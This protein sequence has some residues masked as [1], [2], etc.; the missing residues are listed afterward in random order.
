MELHRHGGV[1][2]AVLGRVLDRFQAAQVHRPLDVRFAQSDVAGHDRYVD[3]TCRAS[4]LS[5]AALRGVASIGGERPARDAAQVVADGPGLVDQL[6][7]RLG[8][9]RCRIFGLFLCQAQLDPQREDPALRAVVQFALQPA[10]L[11]LASDR[12]P[13]AGLDSSGDA[14]ALADDR[15]EGQRERRE[16]DVELKVERA[17]AGRLLD[18]RSERAGT[19]PGPPLRRPPPRRAS[20]PAGRSAARPRP[21]KGTRGR[22]AG[23]SA[24]SAI[25]LRP[26]T[27]AIISAPSKSLRPR[28]LWG[29]R[30]RPR[31]R[32][33]D[34]DQPARDAS[35][36]PAPPEHGH[37]RSVDDLAGPQGDH[38]DRRADRFAETRRP[39]ERRRRGRASCPSWRAAR[40]AAGG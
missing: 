29:R 18:E 6:P 35:Q 26:P 28:H 32:K 7:E 39:T 4:T 37:H 10:A 13:R 33:R 25:A 16:D 22:S 21:A 24:D 31:E 17:V 15:R 30:P 27:A 20:P 8:E 40:S 36:P 23:R 12:D 9:L 11:L 2:A 1:A 14:P 19:S 5:A 38:R 34:H 3:R